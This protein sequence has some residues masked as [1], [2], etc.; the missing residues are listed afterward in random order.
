MAELKKVELN[1]VQLSIEP[2]TRLI[3]VKQ[4]SNE[5]K[6]SRDSVINMK[7][8][9]EGKYETN[10]FISSLVPRNRFTVAENGTITI[11]CKDDWSDNVVVIANH[12]KLDDLQRIQDFVDKN[13]GRIAWEREF[14]GRY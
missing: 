2:T 11:V 8:L 1:P 10:A 6:I 12:R 7:R 3:V 14:K 9:R 4:G 5:V 13:K